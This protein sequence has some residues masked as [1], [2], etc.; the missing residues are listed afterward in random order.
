MKNWTIRRYN[1]GD[2]SQII[3][4]F[5][6]VFGKPMGKTENI[7]HWKWEYKN[8][9]NDRLEI[10]LA[11]DENKIVGHYAVIPVRMKIGN[12]EYTTSLSLD[13]MT[14]RNYRG[15]GL[16]PTL[17]TELYNNIGKNGIPITYGFPNAFSIRGFIKKLDWFE[18]SDLPIYIRPMNFALLFKQFLKTKF[19]S[20]IIGTL[21]NFFFNLFLNKKKP[22]NNIKIERIMKFNK[23]FDDLWDVNKNMIT[24][25]VIRDSR[26]LNW[27]YFQKPE[28]EYVVFTIKNYKK[29]KGYIILKIEEKFNLKIGLIMDIL[30]DPSCEAYHE[31]LINHALFFFKKKKVG[32]ISIIM[33]PQ[34]RFY[35]SLKRNL[36]MKM[37]K[38]FFPEEIY[39]GARKNNDELDIQLVEDPNNWYLTWGDT[40]VV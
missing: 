30:T 10:I 38:I 19:L 26:Y 16:F 28:D 36:F 21:I 25:G 34:W 7:K 20:I 22:P 33:F 8:N 3:Q 23:D 37:L 6:E 13:T 32:I 15:Q 39:F 35:K 2:E 9:P 14:R 18:I 11:V 27:R 17:A 40:D 12:K 5:Q 24:V 4:L 31:Y 29:L 1:P